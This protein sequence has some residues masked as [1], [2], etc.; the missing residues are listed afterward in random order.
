MVGF[1]VLLNGERL[2]VAGLNTPGVLE[3]LMKHVSRG[4]RP[5]HDSTWLAVEGFLDNE[6]V[7]WTNLK[8]GR[9]L[10]PGDT[11]QIR[12]LEAPDFEVPLRRS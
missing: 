9:T 3:V 12:V 1:E 5:E 8:P 4:N 6:P 11:V 7:T 2:C 10:Q